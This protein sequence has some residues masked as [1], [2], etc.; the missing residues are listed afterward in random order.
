M[1][2]FS[3]DVVF[4]TPSSYRFASL[5]L[6]LSPKLTLSPEVIPRNEGSPLVVRALRQQQVRGFAAWVRFPWAEIV[7]EPEGFRV[8]LRD[9]RYARS[10]R[11][12]GF[13]TAVVFLRH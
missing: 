8:T 2:P 1:S 12:D 5:S 10:R 13:G 11:S 4:S 7:E 6:W 3:R 9:V